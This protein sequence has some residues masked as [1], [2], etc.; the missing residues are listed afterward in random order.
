MRILQIAFA[1]FLCCVGREADASSKTIPSLKVAILDINRILR[2]SKAAVRLR[3]EIEMHRSKFQ[4]E[5]Q[6]LEDRLRERENQLI[7]APNTT[8]EQAVDVEQQRTE[9]EKEISKA[10]ERAAERREQLG[11]AFD[12]ALLIIQNKVTELVSQIAE[13]EKYAL[14][15][16]RSM[17]IYCEESF[18]ITNEVLKKLNSV[19]SA[20]NVSIPELGLSPERLKN[21]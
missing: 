2:E 1:L 16:P 12:D 19:L 11:K 5:I 10:Q 6:Q 3:E 14:I 21:D 8:K 15:L 18:D 4:S 9:F 20:V 17:V 13:R 7:T